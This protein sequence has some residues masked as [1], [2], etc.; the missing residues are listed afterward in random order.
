MDFDQ[1]RASFEHAV[2]ERRDG[3]LEVRLHSDGGP[4][5]W[6]LG[7]HRELPE[8]FA[9]I[10]SD[11]ENRV[12]ILTGTGDAFS[13]PVASS[14]ETSSIPTRSPSRGTATASFPS[15]AGGAGR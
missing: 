14:A 4:L 1:Y 11:R 8:L 5:Q 10:A 15:T 3:I 6:G 9:A 7:P 12:V 13:G 2:L